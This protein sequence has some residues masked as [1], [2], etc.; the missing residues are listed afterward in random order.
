M[1]VPVL[2]RWPFID[3]SLSMLALFYFANLEFLSFATGPESCA[4]LVMLI[5]YDGLV[6]RAVKGCSCSASC[7]FYFGCRVFSGCHFFQL[8]FSFALFISII[9]DPFVVF[10]IAR[11]RNGREFAWWVR[12]CAPGVHNHSSEQYGM[13]L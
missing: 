9:V 7:S 6:G 3:G 13:Y 8:A 10:S 2:P 11:P 4:Q 1:T 5:F 12:P